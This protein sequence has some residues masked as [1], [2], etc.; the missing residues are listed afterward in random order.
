MPYNVSKLGTPENF[1]QKY[2]RNY[3][4]LPEFMCD[5]VHLRVKFPGTPDKS[6]I[7]N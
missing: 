5:Y 3:A 4:K 1:Y 6:K 2:T 7:K